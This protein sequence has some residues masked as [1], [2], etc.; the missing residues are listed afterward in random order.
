MTTSAGP[1]ARERVLSPAYATTTIGMFSMIAFAAF[2]SMAVTTIMPTVARE[3]GGFAY[4]ALSFAAPFASGV[5]GMVAAGMWSDRRGPRI[6]LLVSM[7]L[8]SLGLLVCGFAPGMEVFVAGRVLQGLGAGAMIVS[9]YVM[10]GLIYPARLQP[11][12]FASFA[13]AWW[14]WSRSRWG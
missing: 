14:P 5:I 7:A 2:E 4:Y 12:V 6:P 3:L 9:L 11:A 8:F 10:V 1:A 13:A